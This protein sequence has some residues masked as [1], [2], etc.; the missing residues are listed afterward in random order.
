MAEVDDWAPVGA[1]AKAA[2]DDWAPVGKSAAGADV[3]VTPG[4]KDFAEDKRLVEQAAGY[5]P[6]ELKAA[7]YSG[8]NAFLLGAPSHV[9]AAYTAMKEGKPYEETFKEQK[10]YETALERQYPKSS[11][12]GTGVGIGAGFL[13]PMGAVGQTGRAL[14]A[15]TAAKLAG[16]SAPQIIKSAA[17]AAAELL[18]GA[19]VAGTMTGISSAL[20]RPVTDIDVGGA[21]KDAAIGAGI[22]AGAQAAIPALTRYFSKFPDPVDAAGNLKPEAMD[23]VKKAFPSMDDTT[24]K[25]FQDEIAGVFR[26]KG[27][28]EAG[29]VEALAM[30]EGAP[31]VRSV[32][33]GQKPTPEAADIA[34]TGILKGRDVVQDTRNQMLPTVTSPTAGAEAVHQ[35]FLKEKEGVTKAYGK[36]EAYPDVFRPLNATQ[37]VTKAAEGVG[38]D[39]TAASALPDLIK[40]F[41]KFPEAFDE[42]GNLNAKGQVVIRKAL[43]GKVPNAKIGAFETGLTDL[44]KRTPFD[45][46]MP[47]IE[48]QL[49]SKKMPTSFEG[50]EKLFPKSAEAMKFLQEGIAAGN[51]PNSNQPF[52]FPNIELVRRTLNKLSREAL[53]EDARNIEQMK[54]GLFKGI[55]KA[56]DDGLFSGNGNDVI[57]DLLAARQLSSEFKN[58]F[59]DTKGDGGAEFKKLMSKLVDQRTQNIGVNLPQESSLAAQNV[60]DVSLLNK[61]GGLS[62]YNRLERILGP[63]STEMQAVRDQIKTRVL[64]TNGDISK[65]SPSINAFLKENG[66]IAAKVFDGTNGNPSVS[67]LKRL[68]EL[69]NRISKTN[70]SNDQK[71]SLLVKSAMQGSN[72]LAGFLVGNIHGMFAGTAAYLGATGLKTGAEKLRGA[73]RRSAE[74]FGA[75]MAER[76]APEAL[77]V[78][79][80]PI[81]PAAPVRNIEP[82]L[83]EDETPPGYQAPAPLGGRA[84]RKAGGRVGSLSD[85]LV[86]A[87]DRAKKNINNDTKVLLSA[88]DN[89]VA[90]ALEV[91]NRHLEG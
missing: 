83:E 65:I 1:P 28:S 37:A 22:G 71:E 25:S 11:M 19:G 53:P 34:E 27:A 91:A 50:T 32:V 76:K 38:I 61:N 4:E 35:S 3:A 9:V 59:F 51:L 68:S 13:V 21:L 73:S 47:A 82:L 84:G 67:D 79:E 23:A 58:K 14:Q 85:K 54:E 80:G 17:P 29:A 57:R 12:A 5:A 81:R 7:T 2:D 33:T 10:R 64:N 48:S 62:M 43:E 88:D 66:P 55:K 60:L 18:P 16:T 74:E 31:P 87:V 90:K 70:L 77:R 24:I 36:V 40:H 30:K 6:G 15:G 56:V 75:P 41:T 69:A 20:E 63:Q 26:K 52:N 39:Q 45:Y 49:L 46:F 42:A 86:T 8:L 44:L 89:H 78:L 72:L